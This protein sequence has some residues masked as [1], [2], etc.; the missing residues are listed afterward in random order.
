MWKQNVADFFKQNVQSYKRK[1]LSWLEML[2]M[3]AITYT[4]QNSGLDLSAHNNDD[5]N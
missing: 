2:W 3:L 1:I 5:Q 4:G